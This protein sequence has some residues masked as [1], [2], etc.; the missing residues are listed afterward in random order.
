[1]SS[2]CI[3]V[4]GYLALFDFRESENKFVMSKSLAEKI[5]RINENRTIPLVVSHV[6]FRVDLTIGRVT[7]MSADRK[8]LYCRGLID[9]RAFLRCQTRLNEDFVN[10]FTEARPSKLLYLKTTLSCF[11]LAHAKDSL[12]VKHVALVDLGAR[13]G[14]L[15]HY[16]FAIDNKPRN[17]SNSETDF[18]AV[19]SCYSRQTLKIA[20]DRNEL[21]FKDA[22]LAGQT[23][24]EFICAGHERKKNSIT[25]SPCVNGQAKVS[26]MDTSHKD[27]SVNEAINLISNI[28]SVL[29]QQKRGHSFQQS[30]IEP[31]AKKRRVSE[32]P[33]TN[34][35]Q[36]LANSDTSNPQQNF[37]QEISD[38]R[39][40]IKQM[41]ADMLSAQQHPIQYAY[42]P[43]YLDQRTFAP[44]PV[45][46]PVYYPR[47]YQ[48]SDH[49][50][51]LQQSNY[52]NLVNP[53]TSQVGS[54]IASVQKQQPQQ[55]QEAHDIQ[56]EDQTTATQSTTTVA[57]LQPETNVCS[58]TSA[59]QEP[60]PAETVLIEA[61]MR[62]NKSEQLLNELF[63]LFLEKTFAKK[64]Q[65]KTVNDRTLDSLD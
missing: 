63:R 27:S 37:H 13:R 56:Q 49:P 8:G 48:F 32:E 55:T 59:K 28:A 24:T 50:N 47:P 54:V 42:Q 18:Y 3:E 31:P 20:K 1:M 53:T 5:I 6:N 62:I 35:I 39:N 36:T 11:S 9:N 45:Q 52:S 25:D 19:L 43:P 64:K 21:L 23:D 61:G 29:S 16:S 34:A 22:M 41:Q 7:E 51:S 15:I 65:E 57:N 60:V 40:Q 17:Y 10:Y 14:T 12:L 46:Q 38:L 26:A 30:D 44:N 4:K 58:S 2:Q 33:V